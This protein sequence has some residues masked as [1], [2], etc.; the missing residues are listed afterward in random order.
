MK[1][2]KCDKFLGTPDL[3]NRR[4]LRGEYLSLNRKSIR[5]SRAVG[6]YKRMPRA[7]QIQLNTSAFSRNPHS[8]PLLSS[9]SRP[10]L[11]VSFSLHFWYLFPSSLP[12]NLTQQVLSPPSSYVL[13]LCPP[14]RCSPWISTTRLLS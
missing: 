2:T 12:P 14:L 13:Q 11:S 10:P 8:S 7:E 5:R 3:D 6:I 9:T 4:R 1:M